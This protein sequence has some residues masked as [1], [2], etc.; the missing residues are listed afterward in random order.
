MALRW[1]A[2]ALN[3]N[4]PVDRYIAYF[5]GIEALASGYFAS[6]D[7]KPVREDYAQLKEYFVE[8][9]PPINQRLRDVALSS[10]A[11]FP[12]VYEV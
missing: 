12:L 1:Y 4:S 5:V 2:A 9:R 11:D 10:I 7:P 6:F 3:S 8:A